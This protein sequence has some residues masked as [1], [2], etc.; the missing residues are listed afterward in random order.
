MTPFDFPNAPLLSARG[1]VK[2]Y[3]ATAVLQGVDF[4]VAPGEI[5]AL[6]G[7]NGAGKSTL[8]RI[9]SGH[10]D[11]DGGELVYGR[12]SGQTTARAAP[13]NVAVVHQELALLPQLSV[14][15]N[16]V[17]PLRR[18]GGRLFDR[19][20]AAAVAR[21]ALSQLDESLA[22]HAL[23]RPVNELSLHQGQ[24]VEL[25]RALASGADILFLDEPTT[26]LSASETERLFAVLRRLVREHGVS[27]VFVSHRMKEI[28][29]LADVCTILRDG[30][31]VANREALDDL[32][33]AAIVE[34]MGQLRAVAVASRTERPVQTGTPLVLE[35]GD[36]RL[37]VTPGSILG[38]AGSPAG[39]AALI[40]MLIGASRGGDWR[41]RLPGWPARFT[42]PAQAVRLGA[43]FVSGD[44]A[45]KGILATLPIIDNVMASRRVVQR[46]LWAGRHE[47]RDCPELLRTLQVKAGALHDLP[48]TLSG[49]N[50]QK[51][52]LAR[53]L[54]LPTRLLVLEEPTRGV[55][56][57]TKRDIYRLIRELAE[58]GTMIIWWSSENAELVELCDR[59]LAFDTGGRC[60]G[61]LEHEDLNEDRLTALTGVAA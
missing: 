18:K 37:S 55:D 5:H 40:A 31:T 36:L 38:L 9:L 48:A 19:R 15:E 54:A 20:Q 33:D 61:L 56:I 50:Q 4:E 28:R 41:Q 21:A 6:L 44:R 14:M 51:L 45:A 24:L 30:R 3:G 29:Q 1:L 32:S 25:A 43:G 59:V 46:Q 39:P 53:W 42:S 60:V 23:G 34:R 58:R 27:I 49:G 35:H 8:I 47:R 11:R 7:G 10:A 26:N 16:I 22:R 57:G 17:L 12:R 13:C 2:C 52:L